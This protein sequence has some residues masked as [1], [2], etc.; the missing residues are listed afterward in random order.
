MSPLPHSTPSELNY[1]VRLAAGL[2]KIEFQVASLRG[3]GQE[4]VNGYGR[5]H[6]EKK[7]VERLIVFFRVIR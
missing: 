1:D 6:E 7:D 2:T 3:A 4:G 5:G